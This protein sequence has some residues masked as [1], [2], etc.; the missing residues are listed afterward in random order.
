M[1]TLAIVVFL[2]ACQVAGEPN[3]FV[4]HVQEV[5]DRMH[6]RFAASRRMQ[7]AIALSDLPRAHEEARLIAKLDEPYVLPEWQ[8][9][10]AT[11]IAAAH[12]I[13]LTKDTVAAAKMTVVT[14]CTRFEPGHGVTCGRM[15]AS[16]LDAQQRDSS[17]EFDRNEGDTH[18][19]I[20]KLIT[21]LRTS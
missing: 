2:A 10:I 3:D 17:V 7:V 21:R 18:V 8:F 14:S 4:R 6:V 1:R 11:I 15:C 5:R 9:H 16:K 12:Q 20:D 13:E 19:D